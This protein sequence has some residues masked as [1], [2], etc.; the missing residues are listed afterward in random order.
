MQ[1]KFYKQSKAFL[2]IFS[3]NKPTKIKKLEAQLNSETS[4]FNA[5]LKQCK[6]AIL[7]ASRDMNTYEYAVIKCTDSHK[8]GIKA[9]AAEEA[10]K[11][12]QSKQSIWSFFTGK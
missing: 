8:L 11:K 6:Q 5:A 2:A 12:A 9:L 10:L 3:S 1:K 7:L 4:K